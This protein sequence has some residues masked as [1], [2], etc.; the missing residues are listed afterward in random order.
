MEIQPIKSSKSMTKIKIIKC[1][2]T[3]KV[4]IISFSIFLVLYL[5][6]SIYFRTHFYFGSVI[7]GI[8]AS[9]KTVEELN[10]AILLKSETYTLE[11]QERNGVKEQIMADDI[12]LKYNAK[13]KIQVLKDSQNS[14]K[15]IHGLFNQKSTKIYGMVTYDEN[16][17]KECFDK[18]SCFDS[19]KVIE[20]QNASFKYLD[21]N[22]V[23]VNEVMGNKVDSKTL[24]SNIADAILKGDA[25]VNL[26]RSNNYVNPKYT[27]SSKEIIATK[28]LLN[29]YLASKITYTFNGGNEVLDGST[30]H[31]WLTVNENLEILFAENEMKD[32][33]NKLDNNYE[34]FGKQREFVTS[35]RTTIKVNGGNYGW[36]VDRK[37]EVKDLIMAIKGGRSIAKEPRYLQTAISHNINDI[38][39]TYVEINMTKQ[40]LWFYKNSSLIIEGDVVT[41]DVSKKNST[42]TGVYKLKYKEKNYMLNGEGYSVPVNVFM[43]FNN[44]IGI[45]DS[46]RTAFGGS[47]YLTNGSHGCINAPSKLAT[48]IFNNID[49]GTPIICYLQ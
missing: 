34:T 41:G 28:S 33:L 42:P 9:G 32:Y 15:W 20:P 2:K 4:I 3:M 37:G 23:I 16:L 31:K 19:K 27:L 11:L 30:I 40:H 21:K 35:L 7:N 46:G 38:G 1:Q 39:N 43:P 5:G 12:G 22:Y 48:T 29:K 24:Y 36:L 8:N 25:I 45:H 13:D 18:L 26:E 14:F 10:K 47:I 44:G 6:M 49:V 17:L